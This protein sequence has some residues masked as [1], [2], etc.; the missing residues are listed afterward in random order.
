M[1]LVM[2][3]NPIS[4][5]FS[6]SQSHL[7]K[8]LLSILVK[9]CKDFLFKWVYQEDQLAKLRQ[10]ATIKGFKQIDDSILKDLGS[11]FTFL[12]HQYYAQFYK[13]IMKYWSI[14]Q[15]SESN[16]INSDLWIQL[17]ATSVDNLAITFTGVAVYLFFKVVHLIKKFCWIT[18]WTK[19]KISS[20]KNFLQT[21]CLSILKSNAEIKAGASFIKLMKKIKLYKQTWKLHKNCRHTCYIQEDVSKV[22]Q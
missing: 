4:N 13:T 20:F 6:D 9:L 11:E 10:S 16:R 17:H 12:K 1:C 18:Y 21:R 22:L 15:I 8:S 5:I 2:V 7:P 14:P 19:K 3:S